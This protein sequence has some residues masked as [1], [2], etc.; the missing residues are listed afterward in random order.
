MRKKSVS[1]GFLGL[2]I[3]ALL[4]R[5]W[6]H[7]PG[8]LPT[9]M[10][11]QAQRLPGLLA[12]V[13]LLRDSLDIP[14]VI[15]KNDHDLFFMNG[16]I[17]AQDRFFQMDATRRQAGGTLAELFGRGSGDSVLN[18]DVA[19]RTLGLRRAAERS[20]AAYA[21]EVK[22]QLQAYAD[23][24][25]AWLT[26]PNTTLPPEYAQLEIT[27]SGIP[28]MIPLW[29]PLDTVSVG[30]AI[31]FELS[32]DASDVDR[33]VTLSAYQAAG[34]SGNFDG[35]RLFFEDLF[36]AA[37][38]DPTVSI[39]T[40]AA[41]TARLHAPLVSKWM[42]SAR[43]SSEWIKPEAVEGAKEFVE[44]VRPHRFL[45]GLARPQAEAP[46]SNWWII[47]GANS[48]SGATML[49]SDPHLDLS[50]P[51]IWYEVHLMV[52]E[53]PNQPPLNVLGVGFPGA[54][55]VILGFNGR[56]AWG[57]TVNEL[58][59]TDFYQEALVIDFFRQLPVATVFEN[60]QEPLDITSISFRANRIGDG[61]PNNL[62]DVPSNLDSSKGTIVPPVVLTMPR[63]NNGPIV[64]ISGNPFS[65]FTGVSVQY[66]GF[67]PTQELV[68]FLTWARAKNLDDFKRGLQ[69][70]DF[71]SQNWSYAD[72]DGNIAYFTSAELPLRE[73]LQT[74]GRPD[75]LPP[76]LIR[77]GTHRFKNEWLAL[78]GPPPPN[79][80]TPNQILPFEEMPQVVNPPQGFVVNANNDP[81]GVTLDN[82]PLGRTRAGG[83]I[84]YLSP[85]YDMGARVGRIDRLI[86]GVLAS[87]RKI[88]F[89]DMQ[90]FQGNV[91]MLDAEVFTPYIITA[92][93]N[94][95]A[96]GAPVQLQQL[97]SDAALL[98]AVNRLANWDFS[99]PTGIKEGY[100]FG[101]DPG[102]LPDPSPAEISSS[103][104]ATIYSVWRGRALANV[105]D[106]TLA[107]IGLTSSLPPDDRSVI[108]LRNLL[109]KFP[110]GRGVGASGVSFFSV[111]GIS[112]PAAARDILLLKSLKE[113]LNLLAS[114]TMKAAF[115]N[116]TNQN[117][118]RWGRLHRI[119]FT[120]PLGGTTPFSIPPAGGSFPAPLE[121]LPGIPTD[122][123]YQV[124]DR[125]DHSARAG[126]V[127]GFMFGSGPSRRFVAEMKSDGG[128][129]IQSLPGGEVGVLGSPFYFSSLPLWLSN[130]YHAFP[131]DRAGVEAAATSVGILQ[132]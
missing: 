83:G 32:F 7:N 42:E 33:T 21:P 90:R 70:F 31:A 132:P 118:Y 93:R 40:P 127:N 82:N 10:G 99:T 126:S 60:K 67:G 120:H 4:P 15:A 89:E 123:G 87:G 12:E 8:L 109:D 131:F 84:Y 56:I 101:D 81:V 6:S 18:N 92:L 44:R 113:A 45:S 46:S 94:S 50:V 73:D 111:Q 43:R 125:S 65:G 35:T 116:S 57:A 85:G 13:R 103:V 78:T 26:D 63:R 14:T 95:Q 22:G 97:G 129:V 58:D 110:T 108:A 104:A 80:A 25:N 72:V 112:D 9:A 59:V 115:K 38:F 16:Y 105:I 121:G 28:S 64:S 66:T 17:H 76:F 128:R 3:V 39:P 96:A 102:N 47:S 86:K 27:K 69:Y 79:Q 68:S 51:S 114:D 2:M 71:G 130:R 124:L 61:V 5:G 91:Q 37:P 62:T 98:E 54:P 24:V 107:R 100:D 20:L 117:D 11:A 48:A 36:R 55:G 41:S 29:T 1:I 122:G 53:G 77:D 49:A 106:G 23:G 30:K 74:L 52:E 75:G 119:V 34:K 19:I 88:S